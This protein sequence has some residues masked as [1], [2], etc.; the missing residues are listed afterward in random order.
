VSAF[1]LTT[2]CSRRAAA[3]RRPRREHCGPRPAAERQLVRQPSW[4][5]PILLLTLTTFGCT[6]ARS[7]PPDLSGSYVFSRR[8]Y[9]G[10]TPPYGYIP[11]LPLR[12]VQGGSIVHVKVGA[13]SIVVGYIDSGEV[14]RESV[15]LLSDDSVS[16]DEDSI[17][18]SRRPGG[19]P[20]AP[21]LSYE[22]ISIECR[23]ASDGSLVL[24]WKYCEYGLMLYLVP[25]GE[26][27]SGRAILEPAVS[28]AS[29]RAPS[30]WEAHL[31][32]A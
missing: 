24:E 7:A 15:A 1:P 31:W 6:A 9:D 25:F 26:V 14:T 23:H 27:Y 2:P 18:V 4:A 30:N 20:I 16:W 13:E 17:T 3:R 10:Y 32:V 5:L 29:T 21:G 19:V 8:N 12:D 22:R 28:M 11:L